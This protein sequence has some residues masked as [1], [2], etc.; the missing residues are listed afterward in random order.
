VIDPPTN[1]Q[2]V[3]HTHTHTGHGALY[4]YSM[5]LSGN[6]LAVGS[7][8]DN[9]EYQNN[10]GMLFRYTRNGDGSWGD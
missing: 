3:T 7:P 4:G 10:Q 2:T 6:N 1:T 5:S 8:M 9:F